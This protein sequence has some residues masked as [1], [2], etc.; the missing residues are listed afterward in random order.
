MVTTWPK[1]V[2]TQKFEGQR[3][4]LPHDQNMGKITVLIHDCIQCTRWY[5]L[6]MEKKL[7][8]TVLKQIWGSKVKVIRCRS[9][10][11]KGQ[12][13]CMAKYRQKCSFAATCTLQKTFLKVNMW[14]RHIESTYRLRHPMDTSALNSVQFLDKLIAVTTI[15][16]WQW[17]ADF[18]EM[19]NLYSTFSMSTLFYQNVTN[20]LF[21]LHFC[22]SDPW[23]CI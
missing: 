4:S 16:S 12:G 9:P 1:L 19:L 11:V 3:S 10:K 17:G 22:Q 2:K 8:G 20:T 13:R 5:F 23:I 15:D 6:S 7:T 18:L 14:S 21:L